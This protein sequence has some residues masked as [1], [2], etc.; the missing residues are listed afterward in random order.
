MTSTPRRPAGI[1]AWCDLID[2]ARRPI[3]TW[4]GPDRI[5]L[6][7]PVLARWLAKADNFLAQEFPFGPGSAH[8]ALPLSWQRLV[9]EATLRARSWSLN[10]D[11]TEI[12]LTVG[13]DLDLLI[14]A[15]NAGQVAVA[16][17]LAPL[18]LRWPGQLPDAVLDG[19]GELL[20]QPDRV[21]WP[22]PVGQAGPADADGQSLPILPIEAA[23]G[24][25]LLLTT[26]DPLQL[27]SQ[28]FG[29]WLVGASVVVIAETDGET[30]RRIAEQE[31]VT[32]TLA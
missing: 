12:D 19:A 31:A 8:I 29:A 23:Q 24:D 1:A 20:G 22:D 21:M 3:L 5:E 30:A 10:S 27:L 13:D 32:R 6:S 9:W 7:G 18:A 16:Q 2:A 14:S 17:T 15:A 11:T 4:Y 25:R 26:Q 28:A